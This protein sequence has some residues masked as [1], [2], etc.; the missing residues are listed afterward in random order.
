MPGRIVPIVNNEVYHI[1][2]RGSDKRDIFLQP[3][4]YKRFI[5]TFYYYH[6]EGPKPRLS[7]LNKNNF[8]HFKP[9]PKS[10]LVEIFCYCLMPNHFH[11][12]VRQLKTHGISIFMS[13]LANS[14]T[15]YFN[16]KRKRIGPL[17]QGAFKTTRIENDAQLIHLS[18]YIHLNPVVSGIV[19]FPQDYVWSSYA[20]Y[21][22]ETQG[23]CSTDLV[24]NLFPSKEKYCEFTEA[25]ISYGKTLEIVKHQIL[26]DE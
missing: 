12:M 18:R 23:I 3:R 11:F 24:L 9:D 1:Y 13:Q 16:T 20:E 17:L 2:N 21:A 14:Y 5:K 22:S 8:N 10:K 7:L 25:Q 26:D 6:F 4:D 15:K 19:N